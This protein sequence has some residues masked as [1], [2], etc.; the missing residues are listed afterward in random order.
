MIRLAVVVTFSTI[1]VALKSLKGSTKTE[2]NMGKATVY[3]FGNMCELRVANEGN[4]IKGRREELQW[5]YSIKD[6]HI[7]TRSIDC[8]NGMLK[9]GSID[10]LSNYE[11]ETTTDKAQCREAVKVLHKTMKKNAKD[12]YSFY[13]ALCKEFEATKAW[14]KVPY[15]DYEDN[16]EE[17]D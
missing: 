6:K 17:D 7:T 11:I 13:R 16:D 12:V 1:A 10:P 2:L 4:F 14:E 15:I 5:Y 8:D 9:G 3:N